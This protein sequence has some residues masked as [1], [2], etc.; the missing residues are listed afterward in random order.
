MF[1]GR[2]R[3]AQR[4]L[5]IA[6]KNLRWHFL[7]I[8]ILN[9]QI[10]QIVRE[11]LFPKNSESPESKNPLLLLESIVTLFKSIVKNHLISRDLFRIQ[12]WRQQKICNPETYFLIV[13][14]C[15]NYR[16][17]GMSGH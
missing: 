16:S 15:A 17:F 4:M 6:S 9:P 11:Y 13:R 14:G 2:N 12:Q 1:R 7:P 5:A 3:L 10:A 8:F